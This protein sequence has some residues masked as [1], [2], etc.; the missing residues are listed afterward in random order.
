MLGHLLPPGLAV[1]DPTIQG[2]FLSILD[3]GT[4]AATPNTA[5]IKLIGERFIARKDVKAIQYDDGSWSPVTSNR[6]ADG[7]RLPFKMD[8]FTRHLDGSATYG[9][10]LIGT[11]DTCKLFAYD[12]DLNKTGRYPDLSSEGIFSEWTECNPREAWLDSAHPAREWLQL[13]L[14]CMAEG[15]AYSIHRQLGIPVAVM[16]SGGKGVHVY[17][18]TG[19]MP[20]AMV[21]SLALGVLDNLGCFEATRGENFYAHKWGAYPNLSIEVFPKQGSLEGKDL[22]N[23]MR[24][25]LGVNRKTGN[26]SQFV[27]LKN[28]YNQPWLSMDPIRAMEGDMPWE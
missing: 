15:L 2:G 1:L 6:K 4:A 23:L 22:G 11:D 26:R 27:T 28:G 24:L 16:D 21:R 20:A 19:L 18:F 7:Q 12:I 10:Y 8:D 14:R 9:H 25:P 5:L 13:Q 3:G 17:G